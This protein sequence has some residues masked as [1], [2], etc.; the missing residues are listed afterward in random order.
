MN[1]DYKAYL[2]KDGELIYISMRHTR[3]SAKNI[4]AYWHKSPMLSESFY[5]KECIDKYKKQEEDF[6]GTYCQERK[7]KNQHNIG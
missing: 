5:G 3:L 2:I 6:W 7:K 1:K 4:V